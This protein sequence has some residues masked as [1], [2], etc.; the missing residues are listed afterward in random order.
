MN[1]CFSTSSQQRLLLQINWIICSTDAMSSASF[2]RLFTA[3]S[4]TATT[5]SRAISSIWFGSC[6][7]VR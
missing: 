7:N 5:P 6:W 4:S 3:Y 1:A 2:I